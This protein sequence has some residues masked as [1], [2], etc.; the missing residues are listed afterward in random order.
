M[1]PPTDA[2]KATGPLL[3]VLLLCILLFFSVAGAGV[4]RLTKPVVKK[5]VGTVSE[6]LGRER[7]SPAPSAATQKDYMA[8]VVL[9]PQPVLS[10]HSFFV[11]IIGSHVPLL[12]Q[13][14]TKQMRP[15]SLTKLLTALV[16]IEA[17]EPSDPVVISD[18]AKRIGE[19]MSL[20]AAGKQFSLNQAIKAAIIPSA[21]DAAMSLADAVGRK[22]GA[23]S[24]EDAIALFAG[25][26]NKKAGEIGMSGSFFQNPTGLDDDRHYTTAE[27]LYTLAEYIWVNH[28]GLWELSREAEAAITSL[29]GTSYQISST[30]E[31][32]K[33]FPALLGGKTGLTDRAKGTLILLYPIR[34][35][36]TAVIVLLGSDDRFE[37]GRR[38][39]HWLDEAF[40]VN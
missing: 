37:D 5:E 38:I 21:N 16:A 25:D 4:P 28:P 35:D 32:L 11:K 6:I 15:A 2:T 17:L 18:A 34:G 39:I 36:K 30:N 27:D 24:F 9:P 19:K 20:A 13:R 29:D 1:N 22:E 8:N 12:H 26:M 3:S 23:F 14:E 31:L 40:F 10:A 7:Y 33:E